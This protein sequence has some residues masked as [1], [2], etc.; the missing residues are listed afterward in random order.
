M[1]D[2]S[3]PIVHTYPPSGAQER[4]LLLSFE[5]Y[6]INYYKHLVAARIGIARC[7]FGSMYQVVISTDP[8]L[9]SW[10][11]EPI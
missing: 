2:N 11:P 3:E 7:S 10:Q 4:N 9:V 5:Q 6:Q 8:C 1:A